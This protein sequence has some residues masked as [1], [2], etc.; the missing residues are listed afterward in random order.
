MDGFTP[1]IVIEGFLGFGVVFLIYWMH[2]REMK[3]LAK[4]KA[5]GPAPM[6]PIVA[7]RDAA[8]ERVEQ[9]HAAILATLEKEANPPAAE[10]PGPESSGEDGPSTG[11][12]SADL[13]SPTEPAAKTSPGVVAGTQPS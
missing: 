10:M 12:P 8:K 13:P 9:A 7:T 11:A 2:R 1:I 6:N 4:Q 3:A 5:Q